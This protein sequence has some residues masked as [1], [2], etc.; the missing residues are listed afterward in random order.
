MCYI[1]VQA[2][3]EIVRTVC[4]TALTSETIPLLPTHTVR[5][6]RATRAVPP[7][8]PCNLP[9]N[10]SPKIWGLPKDPAMAFPP[11]YVTQPSFSIAGARE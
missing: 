2:F 10:P 1:S 5:A 7:S 4:L 8:T 11:F 3:G 6:C 9:H